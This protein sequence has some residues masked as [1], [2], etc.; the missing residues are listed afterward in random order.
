MKF[1]LG[2]PPKAAIRL[3]KGNQGLKSVNW[4]NNTGYNMVNSYGIGKLTRKLQIYICF[5]ANFEWPTMYIHNGHRQIIPIG[6][7]QVQKITF[8]QP[9]AKTWPLKAMLI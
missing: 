2:W 9:S 8:A 1:L 5:L 4:V 7:K 3:L 6:I